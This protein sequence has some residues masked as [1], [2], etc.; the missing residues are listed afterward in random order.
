MAEA[1]HQEKI[2]TLA[3]D[4]GRNKIIKAWRR[5]GRRRR[6]AREEEEEG[7]R[8]TATS[9]DPVG[10]VR[11]DLGSSLHPASAFHCRFCIPIFIERW[12]EQRENGTFPGPL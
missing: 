11:T 6:G 7:G 3:E 2:P 12:N 8:P 1:V 5:R 10:W 9:G 4:L